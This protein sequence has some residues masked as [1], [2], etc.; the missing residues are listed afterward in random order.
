MLA[1][2]PRIAL[3][4]LILAGATASKAATVSVTG[5]EDRSQLS[6]LEREVRKQLIKLPFYGVFDYFEFDIEGDSV[7]LRG[8][9]SRPTLRT[10]AERVVQR[11]AGIARIEN[12]IE[13][14]P[15]SPFDNRIRRRLL[16]AIYHDSFLNRYAAGS[17]PW[18]RLVVRNGDI[19]LEG[20]VDREADANIA[21]VRANGVSDAFTV[22]NHLKVKTN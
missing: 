19:T 18:I 12:R 22:T 11:V 1:Q 9:V 14:L 21:F 20:Y 15:L 17:N 10:S 3:C 4:V 7:I 2:F 13:V 16:R 5:A 8:Q 6:T